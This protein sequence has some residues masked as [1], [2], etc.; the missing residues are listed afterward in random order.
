MS[1]KQ[2]ELM[3]EDP[4]DEYMCNTMMTMLSI[5]E[6]SSYLTDLQAIIDFVR[7]DLVHR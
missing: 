6:C 4:E 2:I 7:L 1:V 3:L 5:H